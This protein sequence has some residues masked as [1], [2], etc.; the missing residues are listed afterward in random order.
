MK[1]IGKRMSSLLLSAC[2]VLPM[3]PMLP[4]MAFA[5]G[6]D[7]SLP[8]GQT[9]YFDLS[10]EADHIGT[11]NTAVPDTTL[12]YVPFTYAGTVNAYSLDSSSSGHSNA[13][14]TAM[15][16]NRNLF[17]PDYALSYSISW[18]T[19]N[20]N[21]LIFG[22]TY[23]T[24]YKLRS[25][26]VGNSTGTGSPTNNE[27]DQI[28]DKNSSLIKNWS[29]LSWGQDTNTINPGVR[30]S[31]GGTAVRNAIGAQADHVHAAYGFRPVLEVLNVGALGPDG[32]QAVALELGD[33]SVN[34]ENMI[35][36]I[37]AGG[38]F[39]APSGTGLTP[40]ANMTF[41]KWQQTGDTSK[42]YNAGDTVTYTNGLGLT[43]IWK[44]ATPN[45]AI[46]YA[47]EKLTGFE[48]GGNYTFDGAPVSPVSGKLDVAG[49]IGTT[50]AIV[51][52]GNGTSTIDSAGQNLVIPARPGTPT[53]VGVNP[54][55]IGGDGTIT[56]VTAGMEYQLSAGAWTDVTGTEITN[57]MAGTYHIRVKATA[58]DFKSAEQIVTI[59]AFTPG[60][61]AT[62]N[63]AIDYANEK[64]TGF[65]V[66]G[67]YTF[68]GTPVSPV[69]GKLDVAGYIGTTIAIVKK[70]NGTSTIDSA[71]QN[72]VIPARPGT[73]TTAGI[74]PVTNGGTGTV[75][76]VTAAMEY[77]SSTG[78]WTDV[79]GTEITNLMA[80]IYHI[81]VKATSSSFMSAEQ[82]VTLTEP[83]PAY[84]V[85]LSNGGTGASGSGNYT[86]GAIVSIQAGN[87]SGYSFNG[88]TSSDGVSFADT[89]S[90]TTT[91]T[92]PATNVTVT[93]NW[94][95]IGGSTGDT[96]GSGGGPP[97]TTPNSPAITIDKKPNQPTLASINLTA[98]V[99][100]NGNASVPIT[101]PQVKA[102]IDA[103]KKEAQNK[104]NIADGIGI[105][106]NIQF[107]ADGISFSVKLE[108]GTLALLE[109]EG[110]KRFDVNSTLVSFSFNQTAIQEM[111][112]QAVGD[113]AFGANP[114]A[115]LS[116]EAKVLI[117]S[118]PVYDLTVS[119]QKDDKI[120][121]VTNFGKGTVTLGISYKAASG[122]KN[123]NLYVVYVNK[124]GKPQLL[125]SS[126]YDS[127]MLMFS[128]NSLSTYGV[129]Y[130][131]PAPAFMDTAK[132][133]AKDNIDYV[134][135]RG[136]ISGTGATTFSPDTAI[137][138]ADFL[139]ALGMLSGADMNEYKY[140]YKQSSFTD[141]S[142]TSA[143]MPY[144]EWAVQNRIV[145]GIGN[146]KFD[147]D[148][149]ITRE[150][151]AV[152]MVSYA[153]ATGYKLPVNRQAVTFAD[154]AIISL[155][156]KEAVKAILQTGVVNGKDNNLYDP[157]G[158]A[159]RAEASTILRRFMEFVIDEGAE[160]VE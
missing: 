16:S 124:I 50:I 47:N 6:E 122:E 38:H 84:T 70:G 158:K 139:M 151:M 80:G 66:G 129:G 152:M 79:T 132:H 57:L 53:A 11:V 37:S 130:L 160:L 134:I 48:V 145:Q 120:E 140:K 87:R 41:Y 58:T 81:R 123:G 42:T 9:Y 89:S 62:P 149:P 105:V 32:L 77:R 30:L 147:P 126:S 135:S 106:Y 136:L 148:S 94:R 96:G 64:L 144:I 92:M 101:V 133:W 104:G 125:F 23:D 25:L 56:G 21:G 114:V 116:D 55:T 150:Q 68:D 17:A 90:A 112:S 52:K 72:L 2:M 44:E 73:P 65:E 69:S 117:G 82:T 26:S 141:V 138:R 15:A 33:G 22:K 40:P 142:S 154:D 49:Y 3:L 34:G 103:V 12:H 155:W 24:N 31:R 13:S 159:T 156:A 51:K 20:A 100:Q 137:A 119:Y 111:H 153:Q 91:F 95:D 88:W 86:S 35:Y 143:A 83:A 75:T 19:L 39:T 18:N 113:V 78:G 128:R 63:I 60:V 74:D 157:A 118:R 121:Y 29:K 76:G 36:I 127:N 98:A 67:N 1:K 8:T 45:I 97:S 59:T 108:E 107:G 110:V 99:N 85:I 5:T 27:W 71:G 102:L 10:S 131:A 115:K 4:T 93:A 109:K 61:E 54:T 146:N 28:L 46:D 14:E 7:F 43:A